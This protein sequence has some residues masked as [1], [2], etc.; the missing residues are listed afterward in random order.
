MRRLYPAGVS[1]WRSPAEGHELVEVD[2]N[3]AAEMLPLAPEEERDRGR[4]L[5]P[6]KTVGVDPCAVANTGAEADWIGLDLPPDGRLL[7]EPRAHVD[8]ELT[9]KRPVPAAKAIEHLAPAGLPSPVGDE[10]KRG[11]VLRVAGERAAG[12]ER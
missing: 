1:G 6:R 5:H 12:A 2:G 9:P 8:G 7:R 10:V 4:P 11:R 3:P